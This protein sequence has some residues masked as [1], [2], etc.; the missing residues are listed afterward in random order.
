MADAFNPNTQEIEAGVIS[1]FEASLV[2]IVSS[3]TAK[4]TQRD[5]VSRDRQAGRQAGRQTDRQTD[6]KKERK[7]RKEERKKEE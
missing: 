2:Y 4:D 7:K 3:R 6:R 1:K 5:L